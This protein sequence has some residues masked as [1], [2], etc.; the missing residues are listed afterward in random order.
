MKFGV[1]QESWK[2]KASFS[3]QIFKNLKWRNSSLERRLGYCICKARVCAGRSE[4]IRQVI[5]ESEEKI[6]KLFARLGSV[7]IA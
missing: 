4:R 7:R 3:K 1:R 5:W 6:N 2:T